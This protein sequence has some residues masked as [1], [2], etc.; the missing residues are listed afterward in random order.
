MPRK[1]CKNILTRILGSGILRMQRTLGK[2][3]GEKNMNKEEILEL[4]R[5]E[6]KKG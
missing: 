1:L 2:Q 5:K 3:N 6:N 4:C